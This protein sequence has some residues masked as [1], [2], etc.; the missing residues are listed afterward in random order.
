M[1]CRRRARAEATLLAQSS[2][3]GRAGERRTVY[4]LLLG[5]EQAARS[6]ACQRSV[7]PS[8]QRG[9]IRA[10]QELG[11]K[12]HTVEKREESFLA[13][14]SGVQEKGAAGERAGVQVRSA[15]ACRHDQI[16]RLIQKSISERA[17]ARESSRRTPPRSRARSPPRRAPGPAPARS[18]TPSTS[19]RCPAPRRSSQGGGP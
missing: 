7:P 8:P 13:A 1:P 4:R 3:L 14:V 11:Q 6:G 17:E 16:K 19:G 9:F 2:G 15:S 18:G 5:D 10:G 12:H